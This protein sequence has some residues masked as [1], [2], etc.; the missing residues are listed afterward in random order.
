MP[1]VLVRGAEHARLVL[2][3]PADRIIVAL[4]SAGHSPRFL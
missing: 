1:A 4:P 3:Y 2:G